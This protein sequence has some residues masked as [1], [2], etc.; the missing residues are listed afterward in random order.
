MSIRSRTQSIAAESLFEDEF[1]ALRVPVA[2]DHMSLYGDQ[3]FASDE[4]ILIRQPHS[5]YLYRD[6]GR[7]LNVRM[8]VRS[9]VV[10]GSTDA[11]LINTLDELAMHPLADCWLVLYGRGYRGNIL[12]VLNKK[13]AALSG[14][15]KR[16]RLIMALGDVLGR[17]V[18]RL[19]EEG[20]TA[21]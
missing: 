14:P 9:Q 5:N 3:L 10:S 16:V 11:K 13:V 4:R 19:V 12:Q 7:N 15:N 20:K 8:V 18:R 21:W 2:V 1:R 17:N 6:L